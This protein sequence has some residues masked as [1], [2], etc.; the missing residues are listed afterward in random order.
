MSNY[1]RL[2]GVYNSQ[3]R[4]YFEQSREALGWMGGY[5]HCLKADGNSGV[6]TLNG[7]CATHFMPY[8]LEAQRNTDI[9]PNFAADCPAYCMR[10]NGNV[11]PQC[12]QAC[13]QVFFHPY[14]RDVQ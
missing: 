8:S 1:E 4:N 13:N 5:T 3:R 10:Q 6:S 7:L 2:P 9:H 11:T 12:V 14:L